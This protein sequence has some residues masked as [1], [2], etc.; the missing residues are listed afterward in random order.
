MEIPLT[1]GAQACSC[2][3]LGRCTPRQRATTLVARCARTRQGLHE[4][5]HCCRTRPAKVVKKS[6]RNFRAT[7]GRLFLLHWLP[8]V[9]W[10]SSARALSLGT[11][12][13]AVPGSCLRPSPPTAAVLGMLAP[14]SPLLPGAKTSDTQRMLACPS[15]SPS[16]CRERAA[17]S[18]TAARKMSTNAL[19]KDWAK[20]GKEKMCVPAC[21]P[22]CAGAPS[23]SPC[24][25]HVLH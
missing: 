2:P 24:K 10:P 1:R 7:S 5:L 21:P 8:G 25:V 6:E 12:L 16:A 15:F 19:I 18:R 17:H 9:G 3:A 13:V 20:G 23:P 11:L 22:R 14:W 4:D